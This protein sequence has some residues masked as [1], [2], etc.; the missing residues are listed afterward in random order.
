MRK[1]AV[2]LLITVCSTLV[3]VLLVELALRLFWNPVF[4]GDKYKRDNFT[5][6][7]ENVVLN[8]QNWRD[9]EFDEDNKDGNFRILVLGDSYS[10]GWYIDDVSKTYPKI[11]EERLSQKYP[12]EVMNASRHGFSLNEELDRL[13]NEGI[14]FHPNLVIVGVNSG[15][16]VGQLPL[17]K[18]P[19]LKILDKSYFYQAT[20]GQLS[21]FSQRREVTEIF[22]MFFAGD[23]GEFESEAAKLLEM[24]R[25]A[26]ENE[27][28]LVIL[29]FPELNAEKPNGEYVFENYHQRMSKFG[30]DNGILVVGPLDLFEEVEDKAELVLNPTDPHPTEK[31]HGLAAE[32]LLSQ[33]DFEK[34]L[35]EFQKVVPDIKEVKIEGVGQKIENLR[36]IRS[37]ESGRRYPFVY[38]DAEDSLGVLERPAGI[39]DRKG[40]FLEDKLQ[41]AKTFTHEGWPGAVI[42]YNVEPGQNKSGVVIPDIL[43]GFPV[44]GVKEVTEY[45]NEGNRTE[46]RSLYAGEVEHKDG[47]FRI[48]FESCEECFLF[49]LKLNV[50]VTQMDLGPDGEVLGVAETKILLGERESERRAVFRSDEKVGSVAMFYWEG[51]KTA[52]VYVDGVMTGV[53]VEMRGE[54]EMVAMF[55][56]DIAD[57]A[58]IELPVSAELIPNLEDKVIVEYE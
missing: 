34:K 56:Q 13:K 49:K 5:W 52:Y 16:L 50:G 44:V 41:V 37:I 51:G 26:N 14:W 32:A 12:V 3:A 7:K 28:E 35:A 23:S 29:V 43:Y 15:D 21:R 47:N 11:L 54:K 10:F 38:F 27:A 2:N 58:T 31:A 40:S 6:L 22:E 4:L 1:L 39:E 9:R 18:K 55:D 46:T 20:F 25:A 30:A 45:F 19:R 53:A 8:S 48:E 33:Y 17:A 24:K 57:G 42:E 36:H